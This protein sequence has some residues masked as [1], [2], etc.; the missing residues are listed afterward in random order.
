MFFGEYP[1]NYPYIFSRGTKS[2]FQTNFAG[3]Y[4]LNKSNSN[5]MSLVYSNNKGV[6]EQLACQNYIKKWKHENPDKTVLRIAYKNSV[7]GQILLKTYLDL[8][9]IA[10]DATKL[11]YYVFE[12]AGKKVLYYYIYIII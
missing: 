1:V 10:K 8:L 11:Y 5:I 2:D 12:Y 7:G 6:S 3:S 4:C 9:I